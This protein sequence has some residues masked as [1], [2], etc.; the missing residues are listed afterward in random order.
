MVGGRSLLWFCVYFFLIAGMVRAADNAASTTTAGP[1]RAK[2]EPVADT[3]HGHKIVDNY[4]YL[5]N[6]NNPETQE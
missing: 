6:A 4:R 3:L 1:P 2:V 5:E